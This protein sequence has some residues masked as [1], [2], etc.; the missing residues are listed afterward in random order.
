MATMI[1]L[2]FRV[3][4]LPAVKQIRLQQSPRAM[5]ELACEDMKKRIGCVSGHA[6]C[7]KFE[8]RRSDVTATQCQITFL[9]VFC[10]CNRFGALLTLNKVK[11]IA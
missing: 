11:V 5:C 9:E 4:K 1:R 2:F 6:K 3:Q 7:D 8:S 10:K